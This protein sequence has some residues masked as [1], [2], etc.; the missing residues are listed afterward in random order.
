[1]ANEE[2]IQIRLK[3]I[4]DMSK[5]M[6]TIVAEA[7]KTLGG[8][9]PESVQKSKGAFSSLATEIKGSFTGAVKSGILAYAGFEVVKKITGFIV[10][11]RAEFKAYERE[12]AKVTASLGF[13][14]KALRDQ[15]QAMEEKLLI[16]DAQI[17]SAQAVLAGYIKQES[18]IKAII[19]YIAD[20]ASKFNMDLASTAKMVASGFADDGEELGRFKIK[21]QGSAGSMERLQSIMKGIQDVAGGTASAVASQSDAF[22]RLGIAWDNFK[23]TVGGGITGILK[24]NDI[25]NF[26]VNAMGVYD[27]QKVLAIGQEKYISKQDAIN[28]ALEHH[29]KLKESYA[30]HLKLTGQG[31]EAYKREADFVKELNAE[32]D[33]GKTKTEGGLTLQ[34]LRKGKTKDQIEQEKKA[35]EE[36]KKLED[37]RIANEEKRLTAVYAYREANINAYMEGADKQYALEEMRYRKEYRLAQ[38]HHENLET[39]KLNHVAKVKELDQE[40][41]D[42]AVKHAQDIIDSYQ[43]DAT[44]EFVDTRNA[45]EV[46]KQEERAKKIKAIDDAQHGNKMTLAR[47]AVGILEQMAQKNKAWATAY[48]AS[49]IATT[50]VDTYMAAQKAY[51]SQFMPVPD[52]SSP[53]RGAI[54]AGIAV[55]SGA[56]NIATIA[57]QKFA[58]G[59]PYA[60]GGTAL[61]GER[62]QEIVDLPRG[63]MV[64]NN[65]ETRN[66]GGNTV[67]M[68][69]TDTSGNLIDTFVRQIKRGEA[70]LMVQEMFARAGAI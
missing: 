10:D 9:M 53:I 68:N 25:S 31:A 41:A 59:T 34:D 26:K 33:K 18:Q 65:Y 47:G 62:G 30:T 8:D 15:A 14:S 19:P 45:E 13:N 4:D 11:S 38:L 36:A 35:S 52:P 20:L 49:A 54:A 69:I 27:V 58:T 23:Q 64:R 3:L 42:N 66:Y 46:A 37:L 2:E 17:A 24:S 39:V 44:L 21:I 29:N 48:K 1:M 60:S 57:N 16:D 5:Q 55:A 51:L 40:K 22:D 43:D 63:A 70:D 6:K 56:L 67:V 7:K 28:I 12:V 50:T 61:V 32:L